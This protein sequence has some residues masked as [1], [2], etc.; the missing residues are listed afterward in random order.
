MLR[1]GQVLFLCALALLTLGVVMVQSAGMLVDPPKGAPD[2]AIDVAS[3]L[4]GSPARHLAIALV[5]MTACAFL[6]VRAIARRIENPATH[7]PPIHDLAIL[8]LV[9]LALLAVLL[10]VY[11]PGLERPRFGAHRWVNLRI[12][13]FESTQPSEFVKWALVLVLACFAARIGIRGRAGIARFWTGLVPAAACMGIVAAVVVIEDLGTGVLMVGAGTIVLVAA[14]AKL[15]HFAAFA[16]PALALVAAAIIT[17]PYRVARVTAFLRPYEDPDGIGYQMIQSL[18]TI[19]GGGFF[20]RGLGN[21]LQKFGY[22]P[23]DTTDFLFAVVCEELGFAGALL[24]V[25]LY[26]AI[27]WTGLSIARDEPSRL[28]R[29]A[30]LGII[31]TLSIQALMNLL[32]VTGLAPTK[33]IALPLL[34]SGGTGWLVTSACLGVV[35]SI[36]RTRARAIAH[37]PAPDLFAHDEHVHEPEIVVRTRHP[38]ARPSA[39]PAPT[40]ARA[41]PA[42]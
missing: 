5:A 31:A 19:A 25:S 34:S 24:V 3:L 8:A 29:L 32:V 10:T 6:P 14:G 22:L 27:A 7:V 11:I 39:R 42:P 36:D 28:L 21:G 16:P 20:G 33:G 35:I 9:T 18:S 30:T 23:E 40:P 26:I 38:S 37:T 41:A 17:S 13:G 4:T 12:P 1:P 15:V 2:P